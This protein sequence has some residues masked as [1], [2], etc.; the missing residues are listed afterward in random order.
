MNAHSRLLGSYEEYLAHA[1][2]AD[3]HHERLYELNAAP[4]VGEPVAR[5]I[6]P[7]PL[8]AGIVLLDQ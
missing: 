6:R 8:V 3:A 2:E 4:A 5:L 7:A 1:L